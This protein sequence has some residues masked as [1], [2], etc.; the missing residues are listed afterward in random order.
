MARMSGFLK[1]RP[2]ILME[3][4]LNLD[5]LQQQSGYFV[6]AKVKKVS[7]RRAFPLLTEFKDVGTRLFSKDVEEV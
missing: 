3:K 7:I 2:K 1:G 6:H 5:F 4:Q